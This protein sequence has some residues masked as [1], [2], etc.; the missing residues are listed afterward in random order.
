MLRLNGTL[1]TGMIPDSYDAYMIEGSDVVAALN[2]AQ[3]AK[4]SEYD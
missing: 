2:T 1:N 3:L 4:G